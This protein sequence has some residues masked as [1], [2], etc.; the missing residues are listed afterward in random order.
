MMLNLRQLGY[1]LGDN[2]FFIL[3]T[4]IALKTRHL[5]KEIGCRGL[6]FLFRTQ[7]IWVLFD[8]LFTN[9]YCQ[10][11]NEFLRN[12]SHYNLMFLDHRITN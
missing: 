9:H 7:L 2:T 10:K 8:I 3:I 1:H 6:V 11:D 4:L 5:T 12:E